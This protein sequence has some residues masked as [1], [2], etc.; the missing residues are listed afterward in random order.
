MT[1][2]LA[3]LITVRATRRPIFLA[4]DQLTAFLFLF[5]PLLLLSNFLFLIARTLP[6]CEEGQASLLLLLLLLLLLSR[7]WKT[8]KKFIGIPFFL[9][10]LSVQRKV[11]I[12]EFFCKYNKIN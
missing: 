8:T 2:H 7:S 3:K 5:P 12:V 9:I 11:R 4:A 6:R 1:V 10:D